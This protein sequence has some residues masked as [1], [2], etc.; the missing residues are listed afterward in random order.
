DEL[1][2][3]RKFAL[4]RSLVDDAHELAAFAADPAPAVEARPEIGA[5]AELADHLEQCLLYAQLAAELDEGGDAVAQ[6]LGNGEAGVEPELLQHRIVVGADIAR[7]AADP[8]ACARDADF[9]ERLTE[10][11]PTPDIGDQPVRGAVAGMHMGVDE[12]RRDQLVARVDLA[13][14]RPLEALAEEQHAVALVDQLGVAP[15]GMM[16][17]GVPDQPGAGDTGAHEASF[18]FAK[19]GEGCGLFRLAAV[20]VS[21][22]SGFTRANVNEGHEP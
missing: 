1:E 17:V 19:L 21:K 22:H 8:R 3:E 6:Q 11:V 2:R 16:P 18:A 12:A 10:I 9:Q 13:V 7:I 14:D 5:D 20:R 4:A 15:K